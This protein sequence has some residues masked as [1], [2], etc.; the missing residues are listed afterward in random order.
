MRICLYTDTALPRLGGQ[1]GVVDA[2]ARQYQL[3]GHEVVVLAPYPGRRLR[4]NDSVLPYP[5]FRHPCFYSTRYFVSWYRWWLLRLFK[6]HPFDVLHCHGLHPPGYLASIT[7]HRL[8]VPIVLTSHGG[9]VYADSVRLAKPAVKRR[10]QETLASA[11]ALVAISR[12]THEGYHELLPD[13]P[14]IV[15][16]PNGVHVEEFSASV[17][18]PLKLPGVIRPGNYALFLGRLAFRKGVD[19]LL[20]AVVG[21]PGSG[22]VQLV[23]AG[24][25]PERRNLEKQSKRLGL[26]ERV[27]FLGPVFDAAKVYLLQNA[28]CTVVPSRLWEAFPLVVL[29]SYAAGTPVLATHIPGL[30]DIVHPGLTGWQVSESDPTELGAQLRELLA[31]PQQSSR[32]SMEC[33]RVAQGYSWRMVAEK[34]LALYARLLDQKQHQRA[35]EASCA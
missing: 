3:L 19:T 12:F 13:A 34:H 33:R 20:E 22:A 4:L 25:G 8:N 10:I 5:V 16:I 9:D 23:I 27:C 14:E 2:L 17:H 35:R 28:V 24:D 1:E 30:E 26:Q 11:S 6:A 21:L 31:E 18:R 15:P 7:R 32:L 29:E